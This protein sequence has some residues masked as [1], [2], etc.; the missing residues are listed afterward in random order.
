MLKIGHP[1]EFRK[2][3]ENKMFKIGSPAEYQKKKWKIGHPA[4]KR[5]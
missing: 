1:A 2:T 3:R 4:E 5:S